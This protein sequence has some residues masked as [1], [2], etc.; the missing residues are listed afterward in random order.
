MAG[1]DD[2]DLTKLAEYEAIGGYKNLVKA[3]GMSPQAVIDEVTASELRGRGGAFFPTGRKW[4]FIPKPDQNPNPH[5]LVVNADE[6]EP[7][8]FKDNEIM[9][10]VPHRFFEGCLIAAHAVES[11]HVFVYIRGE[12]TGP[13]DVLVAALQE[14]EA[15]PDLRG[16]VTIVLHR[17]AVAYICGEETALLESLGGKRRQPPTKPP[18]RAVQGH[19]ASPTV[20][21]NGETVATMPAII[22]LG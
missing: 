13:Y 2:R 5:Y 1:A 3:R 17:G 15:R 19:Y 18:V 7:G 6:S 8:S 16:D 21:N 14:V 22:D 11:R 20:V 12:Y 9:A 4:S 10:R